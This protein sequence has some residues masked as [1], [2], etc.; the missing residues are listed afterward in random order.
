MEP[1]GRAQPGS[2]GGGAE[3]FH[4]DVVGRGRGIGA[5][6]LHRVTLRPEDQVDR[7]E[8]VPSRSNRKVVSTRRMER[9]SVALWRE[10][11]GKNALTYAGPAST[12]SPAISPTFWEGFQ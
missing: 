11:S 1:W 4:P 3:G 5:V 8:S 10:R 12:P 7:I 9:R 2:T 6:D